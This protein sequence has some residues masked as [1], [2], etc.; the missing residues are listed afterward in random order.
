MKL[1]SVTLILLVGL[2]GCKKALKNVEDYFPKV[3]L[4]A[5]LQ[6]DGSVLVVGDLLE[7]G[8]SEVD[9]RGFCY[10][11]SPDFSINSNQL[12]VPEGSSFEAFYFS[13]FDPTKTYYFKAFAANSFGR[14]ESTV[15]ELS[16][17]ESQPVIAPCTIVANSYQTS[18]LGSINT[19]STPFESIDQITYPCSGP[20]LVVMN[21]SFRSAPLTGIY[22]TTT[23]NP[24]A[25]Q[26]NIYTNLGFTTGVV[27]SG[28]QV[29]VNRLSETQFKVEVCS[30]QINLNGTNYPF[31]LNFTRNY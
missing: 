11:E 8:A 26:V 5:T 4:T 13:N 17:I 29:Y 22:T 30:G 23:G 21:V 31:K 14:A 20:A 12:I 25:G 7:E 18:S 9:V 16:N 3:S 19:F 27:A 15:I 10:S 28:A 24:T 2:F 1:I 6:N